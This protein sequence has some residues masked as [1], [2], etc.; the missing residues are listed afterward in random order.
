[1]PIVVRVSRV[2]AAP[3]SSSGIAVTTPVPIRSSDVA[4]A[5]VAERQVA[6]ELEGDQE[7]QC[8]RG[9]DQRLHAETLEGAEV[10]L[11]LEESVGRERER[12]QQ[13][14]PRWTTVV[15]RQHDDRQ[16]PIA[17]AAHWTGRSVSLSTNTPS[18]TVTSGLMK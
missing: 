1:M 7:C 8:D 10:G 9:Q 17:T 4:G 15:D 5:R 18:S 13:R 11:L 3:N 2:A 16:A 6:A 14:D 12:D